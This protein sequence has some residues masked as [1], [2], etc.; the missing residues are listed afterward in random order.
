MSSNLFSPVTNYCGRQ[1]DNT[2]GIKQFVTSFTSTADWIYK[3]LL[4]DITTTYITP[5]DQTK[6]VY[7]PKDLIVA[8]SILNPSDE[9]LKTDIYDLIYIDCENLKELKPKE[10]VYKNDDSNR[11]H[12]GFIAQDVEKLYPSLVLDNIG[13]KTVNYVE[14]IPIML[15]KMQNM[16]NELDELK[17]KLE[18][19]NN[20]DS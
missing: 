15:C 18:K 2:Q 12:F 6:S 3:K 10:F 14:F 8:G 13:Y 9:I 4:N 20:S 19:A 17:Q 16:Q 5:A 1:P 7:I 11:K